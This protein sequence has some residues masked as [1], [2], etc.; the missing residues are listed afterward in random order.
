MEKYT[1]Q[2][3]IHPGELLKEEIEC[4]HLP[5]TQLAAHCSKRRWASVQ[6]C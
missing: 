5:Q 2:R 3:P 6:V 1:C 4:R